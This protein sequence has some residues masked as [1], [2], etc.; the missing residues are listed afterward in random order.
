MPGEYRAMVISLL[1]ERDGD[2]CGICGETV[3]LGEE[4]I[5]HIL[6]LSAGGSHDAEN[7]HLVHRQCNM[8]RDRDNI[9]TVCKRGHDLTK[10]E[11]RVLARFSKSGLP[12]YGCKPC[13]AI[14]QAEYRQRLRDAG[15][16]VK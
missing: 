11:N 9:R 7:I 14:N 8:E 16:K 1:R 6:D 5:D 4:G 15:L 13:K 2:I 12:R 10:P 3:E